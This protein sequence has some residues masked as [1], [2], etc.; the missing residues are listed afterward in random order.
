MI[1]VTGC[2]NG[3]PVLILVGQIQY[4]YRD[5]GDTLIKTV[6]GDSIRCTETIDEVQALIRSAM[7]GNIARPL[8]VH[9]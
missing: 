5:D 1:R 9:P 8:P 3:G 6:S 7:G 2:N 4:V